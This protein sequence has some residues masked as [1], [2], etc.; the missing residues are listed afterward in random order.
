MAKKK[1]KKE[2]KP[3]KFEYSNEIVGVLII[4][5]GIIGILGTGII[6]EVVKDFAIFLVGTV[7]LALL[8]LLIISGLLLIFKKINQIYFLQDQ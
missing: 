6:G 1:T 3:N 7:Y 5:F 4:L 8:I 2:K